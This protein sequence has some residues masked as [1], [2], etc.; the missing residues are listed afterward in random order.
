MTKYL[1]LNSKDMYEDDIECEHELYKP[2]SM[3]LVEPK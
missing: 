2:E 3:V 1:S